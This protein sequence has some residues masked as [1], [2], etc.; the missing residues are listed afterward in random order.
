M[1]PALSFL[2]LGYAVFPLQPNSKLPLTEHGFKDASRD[3]EQIRQWWTK[4]PEANIGIATGRIS[5]I[6]VLDVDRKHGVDGVVSAAELDLP[7]TL[8]IRTPSGGYHLIYKSPASAI[9]PR[10]IG[11]MEGLDVLGESGYVV[12][13]GSC[14]NGVPYQIVRNRPIA[15]CPE[16]LIKL[17]L[18]PDKTFSE[19]LDDDGK[20]GAGERN[21]YLTRIGGKLRRI[22]FSN[23]EMTA[24]LLVVN[25]TRLNPP[26]AEAEVRRTASSVARYA[27]DS[28]ASEQVDEHMPLLVRPLS[29]LLSA[30]YP[31]PEFVLDPVL[32]HPGLMMVYG[33]TGVAK[34]YFCLAL[35][36]AISSCMPVMRYRCTKKR[37][38]LYVDGEL[39]NRALQRRIR[40]LMSGFEFV[41][42]NFATLTRDD[43]SGGVIPDLN[44]KG[45]QTRFLASLPDWV[46]VVVLDN[47]ST[48]TSSGDGKEAN[49]WESWDAMQTL[50][51]QLRRRGISVIV[52]HHA[53]KGGVEQSGTDRKVHIM[54][55]VVSLRRHDNADGAQ[56]G[57]SDIEIHIKKGRN[58]PHGMLEPYIATLSS[59]D[60]GSL[61]W[62]TG[63]LAA[64]KKIQ[65]EE[66]LVTG[67]P[68]S[69]I[70]SE[71]GAAASFAYRVKDAMVSDG[72][73]KWARGKTG[74][75]RKVDWND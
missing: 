74:P 22:G 28:E 38:V 59:P 57:Y 73:L 39:G 17:A 61:V 45:A 42:D 1:Q 49:S 23:D 32:E 31:D 62:T 67:V 46:E 50:L 2:S 68:I 60:E 75:K 18:R 33:P 71:T 15:E 9:V 47:L 51:L 52:V 29:E 65:I 11:V 6:V 70:I 13:A 16:V 43:Q 20:I 8:V 41:P 30:V 3:P 25:T 53:N 37:G 64:R 56:P 4:W 26:L 69:Q 40:K 7:P 54:D 48:L 58:L 63:E 21:N 55:T 34:T 5:G 44:D 72:R 24:A 66:M 36:L 19:S 12:A 10:R 14:V 35:S 27:P